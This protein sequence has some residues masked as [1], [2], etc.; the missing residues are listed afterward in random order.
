MKKQYTTIILIL[1]ILYGC[2]NRTGLPQ[3]RIETSTAL[4]LKRVEGNT[5]QV[6]N[7]DAAIE[8]DSDELLSMIKRIEYIQ[9]DSSEPIGE[10]T[11]M[12]VTSSKIFILDS[13]VAEKIFVFDKTG[14]LLFQINKKGQGPED[15]LSLWD[16]QV[17]TV[18][19]EI[20][21]NDALSRKQIF[22]SAND[23][24]LIKKEKGIPNCYLAKINGY[25]VNLLAHNQDFNDDENYPLLVTLKDSVIF[26]GFSLEPIQQDNYIVNSLMYDYDGELLYTPVNS[27]TTYQIN[28]DFTY[29]PKYFISQKKSIW[30]KKKDF[31]SENDIARLIKED[32]YTRYCGNLM[33]TDKKVVFR[34][35]HR[36]NQF[37]VSL[38]YIW[39]KGTN[40]IYKWKITQPTIMRDLIVAPIAQL[41]NC[42][43]GVFS[44]V[45]FQ[46]SSA[47]ESTL[48]V[49][50]K[51]I[52]KQSNKDSNPVLVY[53]EFK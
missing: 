27:D 20:I 10:V 33:S 31:L 39:D 42:F 14:K 37:I 8:I 17:D 30:N 44:V 51:D 43:Y 41:N 29:F 38:T 15:Y 53:F 6:I 50:I 25:N 18:R 40:D 3:D 9:L 1:C 46:W 48:N 28:S 2:N 23:G 22:Y 36:Y 24:S 19:N 32:N 5:L 52:I 16:M 34:V 4:E 13:F 12:I 47:Y 45:G 35:Q 49:Q 26:K 7:T 11:K 21:V